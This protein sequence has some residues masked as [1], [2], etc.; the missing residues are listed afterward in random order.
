ME[1][2]LWPFFNTSKLEIEILST[3]VTD[4]ATIFRSKSLS[5]NVHFQ[6]VLEI[7]TRGNSQLGVQK[8]YHFKNQVENELSIWHCPGK[9]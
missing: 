3:S 4:S 6:F 5:M 7:D 8:Q 2:K 9:N 1:L